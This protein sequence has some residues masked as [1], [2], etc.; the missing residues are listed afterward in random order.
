[1]NHIIV[2]VTN[3]YTFFF[4]SLVKHI[5]SWINF[6]VH[7]HTYSQNNICTFYFFFKAFIK[8][9]QQQLDT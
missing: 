9:Y 2:E 3:C 1:M 6:E 8:L 5:L 7:E 4:N